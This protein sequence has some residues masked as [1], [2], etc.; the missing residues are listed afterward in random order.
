[1][2]CLGK[3]KRKT[4]SEGRIQCQS[5][6]G[7]SLY[8]G[9]GHFNTFIQCNFINCNTVTSFSCSS[10]CAFSSVRAFSVALRSGL[11]APLSSSVPVPEL[12]C[13][14]AVQRRRGVALRTRNIRLSM[15]HGENA[16]NQCT[17]KGVVFVAVSITAWEVSKTLHFF[18]YDLIIV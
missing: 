9:G 11:W 4:C 8:V 10:S 18:K 14:A 6:Q 17:I 12:F 2:G 13:W 7:R 1:M 16:R 15:Q 3:L 5:V